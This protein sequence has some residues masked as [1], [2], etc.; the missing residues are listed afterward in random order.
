[1]ARFKVRDLMIDVLE[2]GQGAE[3]TAQRL[4]NWCPWNSCGWTGC[5]GCTGSVSVACGGCS[6]QVT[7]GPCTEGYTACHP[8]VSDLGRRAL[9]AGPEELRILREDLERALADVSR[10]AERSEERTRPRSVEEITQLEERLTAALDELGQRRTEL[11]GDG[12]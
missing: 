9:V 6:L 2:S 7:C 12:S 11:R 4:A 8:A 5:L 10:E 3:R 1:M